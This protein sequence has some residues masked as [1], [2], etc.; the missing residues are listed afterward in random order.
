MS[1]SPGSVG[2]WRSNPSHVSSAPPSVAARGSPTPIGRGLPAW[3]RAVWLVPSRGHL[4]PY[5]SRLPCPS[6][7]Y[8]LAPVV[9]SP[10]LHAGAVDLRNER[11]CT[12]V[13]N[14]DLSDVQHMT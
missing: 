9:R 4:R 1:E 2:V 14:S 10:P 6:L 13:T 12:L 11:I 7:L 8:L 3:T 5:L